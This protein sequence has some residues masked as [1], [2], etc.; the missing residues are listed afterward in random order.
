VPVI[1]L[2]GNTHASRVGA[3][4]LSNIGIPDLIAQTSDE[5]VAIAVNL[6]HD[7]NK[8]QRLRGG[9][10]DMMIHSPLTDAQ[11]FI[12]NLENSYRSIWKVWCGKA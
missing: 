9:L 6:A 8:L 12:I 7:M 4:L 3:S 1:T 2:A 5:Y 11:R 10:R